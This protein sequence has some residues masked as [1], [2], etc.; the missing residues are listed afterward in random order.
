MNGLDQKGMDDMRLL[1]RQ[2]KEQGVTIIL[3]S[4]M[5]SDISD[6]CD[7]VYH[8]ENGMLSAG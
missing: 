4:H 1:F 7:H 6:L 8:M 5:Q 3:A 2:L